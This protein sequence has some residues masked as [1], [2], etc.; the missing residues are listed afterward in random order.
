[1]SALKIDRFK[2]G[3]RM[4]ELCT[5]GQDCERWS[6]FGIQ[7]DVFDD[8]TRLLVPMI[9]NDQPGSGRLDE[10]L[11]L[12]LAHSTKPLAFVTVLNAGLARH[13]AA[14]GISMVEAS[15][16]SLP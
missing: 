16:E 4:D 15:D 2:A 3:E 8:G 14:K 12:M 13:L 5:A 11:D 6:A 10:F 9:V 1:V 7:A